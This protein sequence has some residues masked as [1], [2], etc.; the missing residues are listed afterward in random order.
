ML[1]QSHGS[2]SSK[3][4]QVRICPVAVVFSPAMGS[5]VAILILVWDFACDV[6]AC[7]GGENDR[8]SM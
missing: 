6:L 3:R 5:P 4:P 1:S 8:Q 7:G 2:I